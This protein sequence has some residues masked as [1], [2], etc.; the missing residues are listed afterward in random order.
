MSAGSAKGR[1][2]PRTQSNLRVH[3]LEDATLVPQQEFRE[4]TR[5]AGK[6]GS[7]APLCYDSSY[8]AF[9]GQKT[10]KSRLRFDTTSSR[11]KSPEAPQVMRPGSPLRIAPTSLNRRMRIVGSRLKVAQWSSR[12]CRRLLK[13][14]DLAIIQTRDQRFPLQFKVGERESIDLG[15][16]TRRAGVTLQWNEGSSCVEATKS[17]DPI[18]LDKEAH[19]RSSKQIWPAALDNVSSDP[20]RKEGWRRDLVEAID[21]D[22]LQLAT[23]FRVE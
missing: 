19:E 20:Q 5:S 2:D 16:T 14:V 7:I 23:E 12:Q 10:K 6:C 1:L 9:C 22:V 18:R 8:H 3:A 21:A 15:P 17:V 4:M 11:S 13:R